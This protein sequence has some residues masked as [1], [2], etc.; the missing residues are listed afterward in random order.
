MF[1]RLDQKIV[2]AAWPCLLAGIDNTDSAARFLFSRY[3]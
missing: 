2:F 3:A 1:S